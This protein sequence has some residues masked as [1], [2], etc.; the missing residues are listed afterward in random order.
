MNELG[1]VASVDALQSAFDT[2]WEY[3]LLLT[4]KIV[5]ALVIIIVGYIV[6]VMLKSIV[7]NIINKLP[8]DEI[9]RSA[10][11]TDLVER[12]GYALNS[13]EVFGTL[14]KWFI[15]I[16]TYMTA[17]D[18]F[19]LDQATAFL[20]DV[21]NFLPNVIVATAILFVGLT[22]AGVVEKVVLGAAKTV[23]FVSPEILAKFSKAI[24]I[25]FTVL[26]VLNQLQIANGLIEILFSGIVYAIALALGLA[27]GLG[28]KESVARYL[29]SLE[30]DKK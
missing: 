7:K 22:L 3:I 17:F 9:M 23:K 21:L 30:K 13:G 16:L 26:T 20:K 1:K 11:V 28:G 10:G 5:S 8:V 12:S 18:V 2:L 19:G 14:V 27:F 29:E 25:V 15:L 24:I 4:P 6:A